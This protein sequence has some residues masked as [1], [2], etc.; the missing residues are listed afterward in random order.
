MQIVILSVEK[1]QSLVTVRK[2]IPMYLNFVK[3]K[4]YSNIANWVIKWSKKK[5]KKHFRHELHPDSERWFA[6]SGD[7]YTFVRVRH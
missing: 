5:K 3:K 2:S 7:A 6:H 4:G 1:E